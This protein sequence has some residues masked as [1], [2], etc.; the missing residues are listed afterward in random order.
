M[1]GARLDGPGLGEGHEPGRQD[2]ALRPQGHSRP[3][4]CSHMWCG[5]GTQTGAGHPHVTQRDTHPSSEPCPGP[6]WLHNVLFGQVSKKI[7]PR[8]KN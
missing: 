2:V 7:G 5:C 3:P 8:L 6:W 4:G 1:R